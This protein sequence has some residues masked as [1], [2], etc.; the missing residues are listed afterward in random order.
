M[1]DVTDIDSAEPPNAMRADGTEAVPLAMRNER[2]W[3]GGAW[4]EGGDEVRLRRRMVALDLYQNV[5]D[6]VLRSASW[7]RRACSATAAMSLLEPPCV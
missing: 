3:I 5:R 6:Y 7:L 2:R 1:P 4:H